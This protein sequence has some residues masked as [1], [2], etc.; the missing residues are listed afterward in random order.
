MNIQDDFSEFMD[1]K[2]KK[3]EAKPQNIVKEKV[4]DSLFDEWMKD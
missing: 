1:L 2:V 3:G 4:D